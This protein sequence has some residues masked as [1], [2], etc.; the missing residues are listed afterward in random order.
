MTARRSI[1]VGPWIVERVLTALA[2]GGLLAAVLLVGLTLVW[3][4]Q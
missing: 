3:A 1:R 2:V 4:G